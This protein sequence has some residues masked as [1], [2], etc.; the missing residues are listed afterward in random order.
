MAR[1]NVR[2]TRNCGLNIQLAHVSAA[3]VISDTCAAISAARI[4][5]MPTLLDSAEILPS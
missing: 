2:R 4:A 3:S 1:S 5:S